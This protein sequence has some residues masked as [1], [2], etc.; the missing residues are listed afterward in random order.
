LWRL[1]SLVALIALSA[2]ATHPPTPTR[3]AYRPRPA[4]H[5]YERAP[6]RPGPTETAAPA[7]EEIPLSAL[8]GWYS[9]DYAA[10]LHAFAA[11]CG[12]SRDI[13]IAMV[14]RDARETGPL[15]GGGARVFLERSFRARRIG[16]DGVLTAYFAPEYEARLSPEPPFTAAVRPKPSGIEALKPLGDRA[17]IEAKPPEQAL[18]WMKSEDLFFLQ[19]QGSGMLDLPDGRRLKAAVTATNGLTFVPIAGIMRQRGE[20][21]AKGVSGDAIRAWLADHRGPEADAVMDQNPRYAFF[22]LSMDDGR[23]PAGTAGIPL[24]AGRSIAVDQG[25]NPLGGPYWI[26]ADSPSLNGA[27]EQYRRLVMALDTGGAIKGPARADLYLGRGAQ[28]GGEAGRVRHTLKL[29][30]LVP[31][32]P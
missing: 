4:E 24:I 15:D 25:Y 19:I 14:C 7:R 29:Y 3:P 10:A 30:A 20:L 6:E 27:P 26:D 22:A 17:A 13:E 28:A 18:A 8:P 32:E 2:C 5:P 1:A 31:V 12:V 16:D 9:E 11:G 23:E 21:P